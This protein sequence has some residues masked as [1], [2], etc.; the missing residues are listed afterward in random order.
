MELQE[1]KQIILDQKEDKEGVFKSERIIEREGK[2]VKKFIMHPN[3]LAVLGARRSGKS[4]FSYSLLEDKKFGYINFDDERLADFETRDFNK[5]LQAFYEL[6]GSDLEYI[7]LDEVQNIPKWELFATRLRETKKVIITGSSSKLL[8]GELATHLTGR[9]IDFTLFPF[10]FREHLKYRGLEVSKDVLMTKER[11]RLFNELNDYLI[12]GGFPERFKFG[13]TIPRIIYSDIITKDIILRHRIKMVEEVK[14]VAKYLISNFSHEFSYSSL[15]NMSKVEHLYTISKWLSY[16]EEAFLFFKFERFTFK[17][18]QQILAPKKIYCIDNGIVSTVG[19]KTTETLGRLM[20]N[21][22]FVE[23]LRRKAYYFEDQEIYYWKDHQQNEVDFIVKE[24]HDIKQLIQV[25]YASDEND[26]K[27][28]E[29]GSLLKA[30]KELKCNNL[31]II[32]WDYEDKIRID[33]K[34]IKLVPL[35]K[36]LLFWDFKSSISR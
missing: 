28:R 21:T 17:L 27:K 10:S 26:V 36:W 11:A 7:V 3:I 1:L 5:L 18:K 8:S 13:S 9:H 15:K 12:L 25:T 30:S 16:F 32:T 22:V 33:N 2:D 6:Y 29:I 31:L 19:F 35:W 34:V 14:K 20:E 4:I 24:G 23:L